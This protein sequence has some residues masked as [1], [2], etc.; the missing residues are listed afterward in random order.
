MLP[1]EDIVSSPSASMV[2]YEPPLT[3]LHTGD[4]MAPL[5]LATTLP[6][7]PVIASGPSMVNWLSYDTVVDAVAVIPSTTHYTTN[8]LL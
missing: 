4:T 5:Y 1:V 7:C 8:D 2:A 6:T 3:M